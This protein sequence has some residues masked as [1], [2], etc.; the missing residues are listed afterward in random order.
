MRATRHERSLGHCDEQPA[1]LATG[2]NPDTAAPDRPRG[3]GHWPLPWVAWIGALVSCCLSPPHQR[4]SR[5]GWAAGSSTA[6]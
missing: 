1:L 6:R 3:P 2:D 5:L 4:G